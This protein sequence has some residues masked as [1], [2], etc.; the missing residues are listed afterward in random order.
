MEAVFLQDILS[1]VRK[2]CLI[3]KALRHLA[4]AA[5]GIVQIEDE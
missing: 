5:G 4:E 2:P 3:K 1:Y